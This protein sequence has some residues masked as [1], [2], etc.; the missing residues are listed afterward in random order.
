MLVQL[1]YSLVHR[2]ENPL[3][4]HGKTLAHLCVTVAVHGRNEIQFFG[5]LLALYTL[6]RASPIRFL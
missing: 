3:F 5:R 1:C 2:H 6:E 4:A